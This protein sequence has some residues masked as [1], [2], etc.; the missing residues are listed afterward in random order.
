MFHCFQ[1]A[2]PQYESRSPDIWAAGGGCM[3]QDWPTVWK[4]QPSYVERPKHGKTPQTWKQDCQAIKFAWIIVFNVSNLSFLSGRILMLPFVL[5]GTCMMQAR[6][7]IL[8]HSR[9]WYFSMLNMLVDANFGLSMFLA[10]GSQNTEVNTGPG[11]QQ[12]HGARNRCIFH[13]T[14]AMS[15]AWFSGSRNMNCYQLL[16]S[17]FP[18]KGIRHNWSDWVRL[19]PSPGAAS[20][21]ISGPCNVSIRPLLKDAPR[22][23]RELIS[24]WHLTL[25]HAQTRRLHTAYQIHHGRFTWQI[26]QI[27]MLESNGEY[28]GVP[29]YHRSLIGMKG[30]RLSDMKRVMLKT[31]HPASRST[32]KADSQSQ[33][34]P[35]LCILLRSAGVS[36][37]S[38]CVVLTLVWAVC[39]VHQW[40]HAMK[41]SIRS[42]LKC[43]VLLYPFS[44]MLGNGQRSCLQS[45]T[46]H[47][48]VNKINDSNAVFLKQ[49]NHRN[50]HRNATAGSN[51]TSAAPNWPNRSQQTVNNGLTMVWQ[52]SDGAASAATLSPFWDSEPLGTPLLSWHRP[53]TTAM[54]RDAQRCAAIHGVSLVNW[55]P[56]EHAWHCHGISF[57]MKSILH[58]FLFVSAMSCPPQAWRQCQPSLGKAK[59]RISTNQLWELKNHAHWHRIYNFEL[60]A[61]AHQ[62]KSKN[63]ELF[64]WTCGVPRL[65]HNLDAT[66]NDTASQAERYIWKIRVSSS[67]FA[68]SA[69]HS[70][71]MVRRGLKGS[72]DLDRY[73]YT[74]QI[75]ADSMF[76]K[77]AAWMMWQPKL[78]L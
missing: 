78:P 55:R 62:R 30:K 7:G 61:K 4:P 48:T 38:R 18:K 64:P 72:T 40:Y 53:W 37:V 2:S 46:A 76:H 60:T 8:A 66:C 69:V 68:T 44:E 52:Q 54:R 71:R 50:S 29:R 47:V 22:A 39:A 3:A 70:S 10:L 16:T 43:L 33:L 75:S 42:A 24:R 45:T 65:R 51:C 74:P 20:F 1:C 73:L 15:K 77:T 32:W 13:A 63:I 17:D 11:L 19:S 9:T 35:A 56:N 23:W 58:H 59:S 57:V 34:P 49:K 21:P 26:W 28:R 6:N 67:Y 27:N 12:S 31:A 36:W 25:L 5:R 14:G 41:C